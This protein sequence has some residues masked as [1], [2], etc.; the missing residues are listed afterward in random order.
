VA[1]TS[2]AAGAL[3]LTATV[4][5]G[6]QL[7]PQGTVAF[8]VDGVAKGNAI[9]TGGKAT[10][11]LAGIAAGDRKV[12]ATFTPSG[13]AFNASASAETVV[14][15]KATTT[16][17]VQKAKTKLVEK[18]AASYLAGVPVKG[19]IVLKATGAKKA[20]GK[21][22]VKLGTKKVGVGK[23]KNGKVVLKL[24][25]L[26]KGKNKLKAIYAGD[27]SFLGSKL[28]FVVTLK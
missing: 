21:I 12:K 14:N 7:K 10:L 18:F 6:G 15:V 22:V 1:G 16:V 13:A 17:P 25:G 26:K 11:N 4:G 24:K 5:G 23:L 20:T 19:T 27:S 2:A 28:K 9:V 3:S 8:T